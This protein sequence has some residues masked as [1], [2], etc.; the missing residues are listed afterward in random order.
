M[1]QNIVTTATF[2]ADT[3]QLQSG[4]L[5]VNNTLGKVAKSV[6]DVAKAEAKAA[7]AAR[8]M[9]TEQTKAASAMK[10]LSDSFDFT[11][12]AGAAKKSFDFIRNQISQTMDSY[13]KMKRVVAVSGTSQ[14]D[15]AGLR[16]MGDDIGATAG[17]TDK[18]LEKLST[19]IGQSEMGSSEAIEKMKMMGYSLEEIEAGGITTAGALRRTMDTFSNLA[20]ETEA[21]AI[22]TKLFEEEG[23]GLI[24]VLSQ[25]SAELDRMA[26]KAYLV[27]TAFDSVSA[28][29]M[30]R[31]GR[32]SSKINANVE[33]MRNKAASSQ[34]VTE[35][36]EGLGAAAEY[37]NIGR[38]SGYEF[39]FLGGKIR[40]IEEENYDYELP[41]RLPPGSTG[42]RGGVI[43]DDDEVIQTLRDIRDNT[44][45]TNKGNK[46][47]YSK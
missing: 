47:R 30:E 46:A 19:I 15:I 36:A 1:N 6:D 31:L 29:N 9:A 12:V 38:P 8:V 25:G 41:T 22:A 35:K 18:I 4:M 2:K 16:M 20:S 42:P 44:N 7:A 21:A 39:D 34:F 13:A 10:Q 32:A 26:E 17:S 37:I 43:R 23:R 24:P 33:G 5:Q 28:A 40:N 27:G 45:P 14:G 3:S 11:I